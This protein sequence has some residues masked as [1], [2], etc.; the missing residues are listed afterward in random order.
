VRGGDLLE[1]L[2][3]G[4]RLLVG[5]MPSEVLLDAGEVRRRGSPQRTAPGVGDHGEARSPVGGVG[6]AFDEAGVDELVDQPADPRP[7]KDDPPGQ[8]LDP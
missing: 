1:S 2:G 4:V 6:L 7:G 5:E 3:D 8:F